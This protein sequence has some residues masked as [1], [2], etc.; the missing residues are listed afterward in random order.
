MLLNVAHCILALLHHQ[1]ITEFDEKCIKSIAENKDLFKVIKNLDCD[2]AVGPFFNIYVK[3][4][5]NKDIDDVDEVSSL[6][7]ELCL[8][9]TEASHIIK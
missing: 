2:K 7:E 5:L 9:P 8:S 4:I 1:N 3:E 6:I